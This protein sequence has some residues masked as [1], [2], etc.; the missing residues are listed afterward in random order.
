ME[1]S[2][3]NEIG[4]LQATITNINHISEAYGYIEFELSNGDVVES[5]EPIFLDDLGDAGIGD[6]FPAEIR[7]AVVVIILVIV[8]IIA[9]SKKAH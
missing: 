3:A 8:I 7:G 5:N 6:S 4:V 9:S 2:S 1:N